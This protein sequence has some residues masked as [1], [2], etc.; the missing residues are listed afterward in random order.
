MAGNTGDKFAVFLWGYDLEFL[1]SVTSGVKP[2]IANFGD[3][4]HVECDVAR[5]IAHE[6]KVKLVGNQSGLASPFPIA[7]KAYELSAGS[8]SL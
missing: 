2:M 4:L 3:I 5:S 8:I 1:T 6:I 7:P